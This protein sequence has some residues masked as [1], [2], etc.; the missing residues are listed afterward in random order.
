MS[1]LGLIVAVYLILYGV[2]LV[3]LDFSAGRNFPIDG[4]VLG[5]LSIIIGAI[6]I[7]KP[8]LLSAILVIAIG[9]WIIL[10]SIGILRFAMMIGSVLMVLF[11]ILDFLIGLVVLFNPFEASISATVLVGIVIIAHSVIKIID[12]C[13]VRKNSKKIAKILK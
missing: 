13:V 3:A 2:V 4:L 5:I 7:L 8:E 10:S 1:A 6:F 9:I 12:V 11:G